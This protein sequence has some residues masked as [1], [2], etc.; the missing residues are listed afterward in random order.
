MKIAVFGSTGPT[1]KELII[2]ALK[3]G[4]EVK[5]F[6]RSSD[7]LKEFQNEKLEVIKGN[8][9]DRESIE[10]TIVGVD[11]VISVLGPKGKVKDTALSDGMKN[12]IDG[13]KK[14]GVKRLIALSTGSV[15]DGQDRFDL[16]YSFLVG[17]IKIGVRSAY[18]EIIRNGEIIRSSGLG[19]YCKIHARSSKVN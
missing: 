3:A 12:I 13:M 14:V 19:K 11:A 16:L 1:G 5:A 18:D 9:A 15:K 7:K 2:Q 8:L 10:R 4:Y 6:A 17:I